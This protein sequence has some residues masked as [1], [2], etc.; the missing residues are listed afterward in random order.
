MNIQQLIT[1]KEYIDEFKRNKV[2][3]RK[4]PALD[5]MIVKRNYGEPYSD[6]KPWLNYCR[7]LV[8]NYKT[9][10]LI[11][12]PPV[13]AKEILTDTEFNDTI[14]STQELV[15]G[16][17]VNLYYYRGEWITSTRSNIGCT[18]KWSQNINFKNM[19]EECSPEL[20]Y[21]TLH[22]DY[23]Y[24]F[25]MRHIK[26]RI[27][28]PV[29]TNELV[30]VEVY[31]LG[32]RMETLP[33]NK[34]FRSPEKIHYMSKGLTGYQGE[35]RYKWLTPE[36]KFVELIKPTTNNPCLNY[37]TLR[38][39]GHLTAYLKMFPELR[40][41]YDEYRTKLHDITQQIYQYYR[42]VFIS[43]EIDKKDI[44]FVLKPIL[45][46]IHGHY[47]NTKQGISWEYVK[48]YMYDMAP[49]RIQFVMNH[50]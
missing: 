49:K 1:T 4:Y 25:V 12:I 35:Y 18:N 19:F 8:V 36:H 42:N 10:E 47:L 41:V 33:Q 21:D 40:Y 26:N 17:M 38:N 13:K 28:S 43:K 3:Y 23:T 16:T 11:F 29:S 30:L 7:G 46:E 2:V 48:Q 15:D 14:S 37:L 34:G 44:P 22:T 9:H 5:L 45:Y 20:D 31:H 50:L 24:S 39:S 6:D 27:T 32:K